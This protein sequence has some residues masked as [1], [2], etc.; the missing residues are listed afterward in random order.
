VPVIVSVCVDVKQ[1][2]CIA[3]LAGYFAI[4]LKYSPDMAELEQPIGLSL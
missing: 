3:R 4:T 2:D 1:N